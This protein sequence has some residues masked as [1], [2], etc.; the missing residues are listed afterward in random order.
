MSAFLH[1]A[2][3][4]LHG[5][6]SQKKVLFTLVLSSVGSYFRIV[7][8]L[9]VKTYTEATERSQMDEPLHICLTVFMPFT[10]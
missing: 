4:I 9:V 2:D 7:F 10:Q 6:T 3:Y 1:I 8:A 5:F